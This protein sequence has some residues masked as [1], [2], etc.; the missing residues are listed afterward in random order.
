M[1]TPTSSQFVAKMM[2]VTRQSDETVKYFLSVFMCFERPGST[3]ALTRLLP[4]AQDGTP[5][6]ALTY[7]NGGSGSTFL[8]LQALADS[9]VP[10]NSKVLI[11]GNPVV[12]E[13]CP[14]DLVPP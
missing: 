1:P 4:N 6:F 14:D 3:M 5:R 10:V 7:T 8:P 2:K 11:N 9:D 12:V 13:Q